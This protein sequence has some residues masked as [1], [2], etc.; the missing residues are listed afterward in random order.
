MNP[1]DTCAF[2]SGSV[3]H[4]EEPHNRLRSELC[5]LGAIPFYCHHG[6]DGTVRDLGTVTRETQRVAVQT[7]FI[8]IC[9]GWRRT[10]KELA[11]AGYFKES[12][13]LKR[14]YAEVGLGALRTFVS[15]EEGPKKR[16]A[17]ET[18]QD[19]IFALNKYRGFTEV[20]G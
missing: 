12:P 4:D 14:V 15:E 17:A 1:C 11:A 5:A 9:Q 18:L 19:V 3:T 20:G 6:A 16:R 8:V 13:R 2:R 7:G 10:V